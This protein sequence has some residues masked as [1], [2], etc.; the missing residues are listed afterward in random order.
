MRK[1]IMKICHSLILLSATLSLVHCASTQKKP[2]IYTPEA[3]L[4]AGEDFT[5][6][7]NPYTGEKGKARKGIIAATLNN[8]VLLNKLLR[9]ERADQKQILA[10]IDAVKALLPSLNNVGIF[11]FF[12]VEEW[13]TTNEQPG[14]VLVAALYL[15]AYPKKLTGPARSLLVTALQSAANPLFRQE[16]QQT[17]ATPSP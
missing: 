9:D 10:I 4:P 15:Q 8:V 11:D 14:R 5:L 6:A 16:L 7:T 1:A 12:H 17:L 13:L 3:I 2:E